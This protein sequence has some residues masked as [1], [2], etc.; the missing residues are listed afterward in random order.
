MQPSRFACLWVEPLWLHSFPFPLL[1]NRDT[2]IMPPLTPPVH[3]RP[4]SHLSKVCALFLS[5]FPFFFARPCS[6]TREVKIKR[7]TTFM[8]SPDDEIW[9]MCGTE[10]I[11]IK[12][13]SYDDIPPGLFL[14]IY[15]KF[16]IFF[17]F[18]NFFESCE[19]GISIVFSFLLFFRKSTRTA[20]NS[21]VKYSK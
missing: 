21:V 8:D 12:L 10:E 15:F 13:W 20:R 1:S 14:F 11:Y 19:F 7:F 4:L 2:V 18:R 9:L 16:P 6:R 17:I 3:T 5:Q